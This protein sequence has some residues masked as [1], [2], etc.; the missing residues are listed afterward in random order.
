MRRQRPTL[1]EGG[2]DMGDTRFSVRIS[3]SAKDQV[4][5]YADAHGVRRNHLVATAL[6]HHVQALRELPADLVIP[7]RLTLTSRSFREVARL[8]RK[9]RRP[10]R[11]LRALVA[12]KPV[13][14]EP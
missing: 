2:I 4:E 3:A 7:P 11:A 1:V 10:S 6:L 8:V 13:A 14:D 5:R 9:P 12:G